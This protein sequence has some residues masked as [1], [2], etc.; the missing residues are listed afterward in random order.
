MSK[1]RQN[2]KNLC[3]HLNNKCFIRSISG[4]CNEKD[5]MIF[6]SFTTKGFKYSITASLFNTDG[7]I[8]ILCPICVS[9]ENHKMLNSLLYMLNCM[10]LYVRLYVLSYT[11][12]M[13]RMKFKINMLNGIIPGCDLDKIAYCFDEYSVFVKCVLQQQENKHHAFQNA[14]N[15]FALMVLE[16]NRKNPINI[17]IQNNEFYM[18]LYYL[19]FYS[20]LVKNVNHNTNI[21]LS[22]EQLS[23]LKAFLEDDDAEDE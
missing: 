21:E 17:T 20:D 4:C 5:N 19:T 9:E 16:A 13:V 11:D 23:E 6:L 7:E 3:Q 2:A 14:A 22:L 15:K 18:Y 10:H 8:S 1:L 12:Y